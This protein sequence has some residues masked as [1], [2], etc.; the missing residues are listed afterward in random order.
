MSERDIIEAYA[1][2]LKLGSVK[3]NVGI[4]AEDAVREQWGYLYF[5]KRLLEEE[6]ARRREKSKT[7][8]I[9]KANFPQMK[10]LE[11]LEWSE[12]PKEGQLLLTEAETLDFIKEGRS[13]VMYGNPGDGENAYS[14]RTRYKG[15]PRRV[16]CVLH[17]RTEIADYDT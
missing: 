4:F 16:L 11:E 9:H 17:I 13:I 1:R 7:T 10:Y 14:H 8:R 3:E 15:M 5:L 6:I 2:E 12:L